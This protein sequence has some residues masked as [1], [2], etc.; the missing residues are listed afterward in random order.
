MFRHEL[1]GL[2]LDAVGVRNSD[3][4]GLFIR[5]AYRKIDAILAKHYDTLCPPQP[6]EVKKPQN[7]RVA[8]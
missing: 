3:E 4:R 8:V 2:L 1:G 7:G 6:L 5:V